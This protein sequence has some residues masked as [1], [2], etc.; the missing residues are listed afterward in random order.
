MFRRHHPIQIEI[1]PLAVSCKTSHVAVRMDRIA[2]N[3]RQLDQLLTEVESRMPT[4]EL[5][6]ESPMAANEPVPSNP[7]RPQKPR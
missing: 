1:D 7:F 4:F 3:Y 5:T 6:A 2:E